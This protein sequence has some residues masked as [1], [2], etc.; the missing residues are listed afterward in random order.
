MK[1]TKNARENLEILFP[2]NHNSLVLDDTD[3]MAMFTNLAFDEII[4]KSQLTTRIRFMTNL[5]ILIGANAQD[6][7]REILPAVLNKG[8]SPEEIKAITYQ[9]IS[10]LGMGKL[11]PS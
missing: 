6:L 4:E 1:L 11:T 5:A 9:N 2:V 7:Y 3:F 8:L 10:Y